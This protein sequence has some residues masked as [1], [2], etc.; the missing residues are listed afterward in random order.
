MCYNC[1]CEDPFDDMGKGIISKGGASLTEEDLK[2][3]AKE[4][5]M[6]IDDVKKNI[7]D[8]LKKDLK[9]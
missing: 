5:G 3:I 9:K 8:L 7:Y 4:W 2:K 6:D 1:G